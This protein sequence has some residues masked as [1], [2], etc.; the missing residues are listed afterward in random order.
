MKE[1]E[2]LIVEVK[3]NTKIVKIKREA[4]GKIKT[5][6]CYKLNECGKCIAHYSIEELRG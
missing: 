2:F 1:C 5:I 3:D 4:V 6:P